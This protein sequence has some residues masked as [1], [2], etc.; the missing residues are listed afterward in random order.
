MFGLKSGVARSSIEQE[1]IVKQ[2]QFLP[3]WEI[4]PI[5]PSNIR[6]KNEDAVYTSR[7]WDSWIKVL[8]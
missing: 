2:F 7:A 5:W 4:K 8:C 1:P 3:P 6:L